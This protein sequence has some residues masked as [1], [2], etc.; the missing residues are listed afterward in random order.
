RNHL[1]VKIRFGDGV[2]ADLAS[3]LGEEG[4]TRPFVIMDRELDR[5]VPGVAAA[6]A[7]LAA[8]VRFE[9]EPGEP[10]VALVEEAASVLSQAGCDA[11]VAIGGGSA[12][13]TAKAARLVAGQGGPYLRFARGEAGY[14]PPR[15]PLV[16][17]PTTAGTGSEVS[18][19]AVI[20][21]QETHVKA[22]IA[23]PLLRAQHALVD[24]VLTHGLPRSV[25]AHTGIDA[26]AQA[27]AALVVTARTPVGDAVGLEATRLAGRS[28]VTAVRDGGNADARSAMSCAS[29]LAG[30]AMNISDCGS[31]H[32]LAQAIGGLLGLPHGLTVGLVLAETM[33]RDRHFVPRQFERVAD[34]LGEPDDGSGDGSRAV[35]A[36]RRILAELEFDTM[37]SVG[38][39]EEHLDELAGKA[40]ADYF[41]SVA[42]SPWS[43]DEVKDAYRAGLALGAAR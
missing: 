25:T 42:P 13:D 18:G 1:P 39:R 24:P 17:I 12:M 2:S 20:T 23:S 16:C 3:V 35:R 40:L 28:L 43:P 32:S 31:E 30:L 29:L 27:I 7:P 41:I 11:V 6:L 4:A 5:L 33:D 22:G 36:V 38:V 9:K 14:E 34:A 15:I 21:D 37:Q 10:T 8:T 19:G 26:L